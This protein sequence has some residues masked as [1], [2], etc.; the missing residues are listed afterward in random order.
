MPFDNIDMSF[1]PP[2][3]APFILPI[4]IMFVGISLASWVMYVGSLWLVYAKANR[5]GWLIFI[6]IVNV[7]TMLRIA[8]HPAWHFLLL[9]IP[10]VNV[11][12]LMVVWFNLA[13]AFGKGTV[14]GLGLLFFHWLFVVWLAFG[15]AEYQLME[16]PKSSIDDFEPINVRP[17]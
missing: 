12:L 17:T 6:P 4:T 8:G 5:A 10:I 11:I 15:R 3:I 13:K 2:E 14:F 9:L 7:Y 1:I 16:K